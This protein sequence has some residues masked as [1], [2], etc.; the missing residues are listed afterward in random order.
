MAIRLVLKFATNSMTGSVFLVVLVAAVEIL[1]A[2][3]AM[4]PVESTISIDAKTGFAV[5]TARYALAWIAAAL[6]A[7]LGGVSG[8]KFSIFV[9][10]VAVVSF[11]GLYIWHAHGALELWP[12]I[13]AID[14]GLFL[15]CLPIWNWCRSRL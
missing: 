1:F 2:I 15:P 6:L 3:L 5:L 13:F 11:H 9:I 14:I 12:P 7:R 4:Q 10:G 8:S